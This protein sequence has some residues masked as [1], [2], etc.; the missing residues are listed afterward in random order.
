MPFVNS[1]RGVHGVQSGVTS[2]GLVLDL[3]TGGTITT[4]GDYRI[5]TFT[6]SGTFQTY[7]K[8]NLEVLAVGGGGNGYV[9]PTYGGGGGGGCYQG[10]PGGNG[11]SGVI[12]MKYSTVPA[13]FSVN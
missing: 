1:M 11:G 4:S 5:H 10:G 13:V 6:T 7:T 3:I 9:H 8:L 2:T 12:I